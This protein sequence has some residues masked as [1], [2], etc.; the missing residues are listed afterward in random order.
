MAVVGFTKLQEIFRKGASLDIHKGHA[1]EITD[2]VEQK[3]Y[4]MLLVGQKN[5][6]YNA[7]DVVWLADMPITKG[8]EETMDTF[9]KLEEEVD[10]KDVT[11][12]LASYPPVIALETELEAKLPEIAGALLLT[13]AKTMKAID[14]ADKAVDHELIN[15]AHKVL[16]ITM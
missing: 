2:I 15:K 12:M 6:K 3:L 13:L 14:P 1:K 9:K 8:F 7:R 11:R 10:A 16:N 4:D 5:A